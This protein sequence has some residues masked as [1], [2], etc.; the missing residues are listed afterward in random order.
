MPE[1]QIV[2]DGAVTNDELNALFAAAWSGH[3]PRDF[4]PVLARSLVYYAAR[5]QEQLVGFVNVAWDGGSHAFLLDTTVHPTFQ[6]RGIGTQLVQQAARTVRSHGIEW[7][8]VDFEPGLERF[9][10]GAGFRP[11]AA[12]VWKLSQ[13]SPSER[14]R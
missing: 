5:E 7:L 9:Y 6:R 8:H 4:T 14:R 3:E 2:P 12:A 10:L 1:L 13:S 11:T